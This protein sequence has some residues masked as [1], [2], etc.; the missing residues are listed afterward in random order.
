MR[1]DEFR[2]STRLVLQHRKEGMDLQK[3][4]VSGN[5]AIDFMTIERIAR[6]LLNNTF[7]TLMLHDSATGV[8][9]QVE[10]TTVCLEHMVLLGDTEEFDVKLA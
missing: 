4:Y 7:D 8:M 6:M 5:V 1:Y 10:I 3:K 2:Q 9:V